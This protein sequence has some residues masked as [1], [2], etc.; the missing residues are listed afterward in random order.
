MSPVN[1][2]GGS[3]S[4]TVTAPSRVRSDFTRA[5]AAQSK[6]S[7]VGLPRGN[8]KSFSFCAVQFLRCGVLPPKEWIVQHC[9]NTNV[10]SV[11]G[12][13]QLYLFNLFLI[14]II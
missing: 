7:L 6:M 4:P 10:C 11:L 5:L 3:T 1:G 2:V 8:S 9:N 12:G 13:F 14:C